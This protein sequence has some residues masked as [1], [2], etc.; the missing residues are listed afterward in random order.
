MAQNYRTKSGK[1]FSF[2]RRLETIEEA[3]DAPVIAGVIV[4]D[5]SEKMRVLLA[6]TH[7]KLKTKNRVAPLSEGS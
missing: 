7:M 1:T 2:R 5:S 6:K 3:P 4:S